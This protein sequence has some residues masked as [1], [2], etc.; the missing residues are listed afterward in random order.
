MPPTGRA[1]P[2][3]PATSLAIHACS[4]SRRRDFP[5]FASTS[6]CASWASERTAAQAPEIL[7]QAAPSPESL[8]APHRK[9]RFLCSLGAGSV[10][11]LRTLA[12][13]LHKR[14]SFPFDASAYAIRNCCIAPLNLLLP[15]PPR[16]SFLLQLCHGVPNIVLDLPTA[17]VPTGTTSGRSRARRA[18]P[19]FCRRAAV[20][21]RA[22]S[23][24]ARHAKLA[25][26]TDKD[27]NSGRSNMFVRFVLKCLFLYLFLL[28][29]LVI[30]IL[31]IVLRVGVG[32]VEAPRL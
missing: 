17:S 1:H 18:R 4:A 10:L 32:S 23:I 2:A 6:G 16:H 13:L 11:R 14:I 9:K 22:S 7:S 26:N 21:V 20:S 25:P 5:S 8:P 27:R 24:L 28:V 31:V 12:T 29:I 30:V 19:E 3:V 15:P